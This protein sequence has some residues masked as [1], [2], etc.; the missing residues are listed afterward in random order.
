M[1]TDLSRTHSC[2]RSQLNTKYKT[3]QLIRFT[4][5]TKTM[6]GLR[7]GSNKQPLCCEANYQTRIYYSMALKEA[8]FTT[9]VTNKII[10]ATN[11]PLLKAQ[12][13]R[14]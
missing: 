4:W 9:S 1:F 3:R 6:T 10:D 5:R 13:T 12:S 11:N 2:A 7:T 14:Y 8:Q